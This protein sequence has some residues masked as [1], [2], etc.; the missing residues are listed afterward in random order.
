MISHRS[1]YDIQPL[2]Y[3]IVCNTAL[4]A[5]QHRMQY[6]IVYMAVQ[7]PILHLPIAG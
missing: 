4:Y 3:S 5:I 6:S 1:V 2:A 7:N